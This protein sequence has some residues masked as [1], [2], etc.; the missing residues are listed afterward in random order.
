MKKPIRIHGS[1]FTQMLLHQLIER[2]ICKLFKT[3]TPKS[4]NNLKNLVKEIICNYLRI[5]IIS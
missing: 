4:L 5:E 1:Y 2:L 3:D